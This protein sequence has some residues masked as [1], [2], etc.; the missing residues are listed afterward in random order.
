M[1]KLMRILKL[2]SGETWIIIGVI[3]G[4]IALFAVPY[5][6]HLKSM[7]QSQENIEIKQ[8]TSGAQSPN[9]IS[10]TTISKGSIK[11]KSSGARSP[12]I[13]SGEENS[14]VTYDTINANTRNAEK[15]KKK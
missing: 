1:V 6:F 9:I 10:E 14:K 13:I 15:Q 4:A 7:K 12:N 5:G 11:Q 3:C 2:M 8:E